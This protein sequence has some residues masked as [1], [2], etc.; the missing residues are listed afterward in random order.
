MFQITSQNFCTCSIES[1]CTYT[2]MPGRGIWFSQLSV[3][4]PRHSG[5]GRYM[6]QRSSK[7]IFD[8]KYSVTLDIS[9]WSTTAARMTT[10]PRKKDRENARV[11]CVMSDFALLFSNVEHVRKKGTDRA[12]GEGKE[13]AISWC[14]G[15]TSYSILKEKCNLSRNFARELSNWNDYAGKCRP[16]KFQR[17][18]YREI[19]Y[20]QL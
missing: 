16:N 18:G 12:G 14:H 10:P 5:C 9:D 3:V 1:R 2:L 6:T 19:S 13:M 15:F 17:H 7:F 8:D 4:H 11:D 20:L